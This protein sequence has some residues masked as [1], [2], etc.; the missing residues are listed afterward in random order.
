M[1]REEE[2]CPKE[3]FDIMNRELTVPTIGEV[4]SLYARMHGCD[5]DGKLPIHT[6]CRNVIGEVEKFQRSYGIKDGM[7]ITV[8]C[9]DVL[10]KYMR[11]FYGDRRNITK[12]GVCSRLRAFVGVNERIYYSQFGYKVEPIDIPSIKDDSKAYES[13]VGDIVMK[14]LRWYRHLQFSEDPRERLFATLMLHFGMRNGDVG[15]AKWGIFKKYGDMLRL[16]YI[17]HKTEIS[18]SGRK[19]KIVA[20]LSDQEELMEARGNAGDDEYIIARKWGNHH[21]GLHS[22]QDRMNNSLRELGF[23]ESKGLYELRKM[24]IDTVW[25]TQGA[26]AAAA[27][28]GDAINT[29]GFY[30]ADNS[31]K[32]VMSLS[33]SSFVSRMRR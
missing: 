31:S 15:R 9:H 23:K 5:E 17:P 12:M 19:V 25:Q 14:V 22:L 30:Y 13:K 33:D 29:A 4:K 2:L 32:G 10:A 8:I 26:E 21:A 28:S 20:N 27:F 24:A 3:I 6:H 1:E 11:D 18:A 16:E 7:K